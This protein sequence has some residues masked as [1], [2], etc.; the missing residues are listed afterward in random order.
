MLL[1][2][3]IQQSCSVLVMW[4]SWCLFPWPLACLCFCLF[5]YSFCSS[6]L[7]VPKVLAMGNNQ[8]YPLST[9]LHKLVLVYV[10]TMYHWFN[11]DEVRR[12]SLHLV[13]WDTTVWGIA[14]SGTTHMKNIYFKVLVLISKCGWL[15]SWATEWK[16]IST[17]VII[18][19]NIWS[20]NTII[21]APRQYFCGSWSWPSGLLL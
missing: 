8:V 7:D 3:Y 11:Q 15:L 2:Y 14:T 9:R 4:V 1:A 16:S 18:L 5:W 6:T 12:F 19:D 17:T 21:W 10:P 20:P 13:D